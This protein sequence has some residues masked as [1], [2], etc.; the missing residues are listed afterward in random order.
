MK[1]YFIMFMFIA[2]LVLSACGD[3]EASGDDSQNGDSKEFIFALDQGER[4]TWVRATQ[5]FAELIEEKT[6]GSITVSVHHSGTLGSQR[7]ALEGIMNGTIHGT[8]P[9]EPLSYWVEEINLYGIPYLFEDEAH[10]EEFL[11]SEHGE[12]LHQKLVDNNFRPA[13]YFNRP[14]RQITSNKPINSLED[15]QGLAIRVPETDTAP[16]AF[17]AMGASP[18][19]MPFSDL[20]N[21]LETG[22]IDAQENPITTTYTNNFHEIQSHFAYTNHQYQ[23]GYFIFSE[24]AYQ[25]LTDEEQQAFD[26]AVEEMI[27]FEAEILAEDM[28]T[29]K[30]EML[31][32]GVTF[33]EPDVETFREAAQDAYEGYDDLMK[34]WIEK[35]QSLR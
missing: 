15:L 3:N 9:L 21:A 8:V 22:T 25:T 17:Q 14:P 30:D 29:T 16:A 7:E 1:K 34:E 5:K 11:S 35:V 28:E 13:G 18:T 33:T 23:V 20:Y 27:E 19:T 6:D 32:Y 12:E 10:L 4:D 26:E 31:N 2:L 24:E